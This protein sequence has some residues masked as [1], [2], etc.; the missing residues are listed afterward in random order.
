MERVSQLI[1]VEDNV[2]R[3]VRAEPNPLE[4]V[5][6]GSTESAVIGEEGSSDL[7]VDKLPGHFDQDD[8]SC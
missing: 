1:P 3:A 6:F 7:S 5:T 8:S 2:L 4:R